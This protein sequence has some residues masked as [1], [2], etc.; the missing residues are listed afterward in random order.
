M[1]IV[2]SSHP[3]AQYAELTWRSVAKRDAMNLL[4]IELKT[5]RP[6]QIRIQ[7]AH[8]GFPVLGDLRYGAKKE[9][10]GK[11]VALHCYLLGLEHPVKKELM[12]WVAKPSSTWYGKFDDGIEHIISSVQPVGV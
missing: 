7:L 10:D 8:R 9:F 4:E 12:K 5:G 1:R 2:D 3:K 6:H 11:N